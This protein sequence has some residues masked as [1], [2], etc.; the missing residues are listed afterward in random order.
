MK[1]NSSAL[2][3]LFQEE[4]YAIPSAVLIILNEDWDTIPDTDKTLLIKILGSVKLS[5]ASVQ[6]C[7]RN[8]FTMDEL[9]AFSPAR[10]IAFGAVL[11]TQQLSYEHHTINGVS[12]V[13]ADQLGHLDDAKKK[14]LWMALKQM[15]NI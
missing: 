6:I 2:E 5:L 12:I 11:N 10:I 13:L 3:N 15:F 4:L 8:E 7:K 14:R 1:Y 9:D